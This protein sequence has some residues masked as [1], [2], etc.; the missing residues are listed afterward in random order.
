MAFAHAFQ[1]VTHIVKYNTLMA[2]ISA[3][4]YRPNHSIHNR[5]CLILQEL[6]ILSI[7]ELKPADCKHKWY[8]CRMLLVRDATLYDVMH[9]IKHYTHPVVW[10]VNHEWNFSIYLT[11]LWPTW[12]WTFPGG[13]F[14]GIAESHLVPLLCSAM[15]AHLKQSPVTFTDRLERANVN[16]IT[17]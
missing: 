11:V 2:S 15:S 13:G 5:K 8:E 7:W 6:Q 10:V 17:H 16:K 12:V 1:F 9:T 14:G 4:N 3:R